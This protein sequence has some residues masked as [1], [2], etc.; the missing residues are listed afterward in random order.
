[1]QVSVGKEI[2]L[3]AQFNEQLDRE[4]GTLL[5]LSVAAEWI[6]LFDPATD[7]SIR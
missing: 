5:T 6:Y 3:V 2:R 4:P 1:M 7:E